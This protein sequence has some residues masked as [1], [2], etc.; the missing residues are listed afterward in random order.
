MGAQTRDFHTISKY[1]SM[2]S[3]IAILV[4]LI[5]IIVAL[6]DDAEKDVGTTFPKNTTIVGVQ[7]GT[8][9]FDFLQSLSSIVFA[10]QGQSIFME[11]M[12]EMKKP[13]EF[14]KSLNVAYLLM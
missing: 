2:P 3:T 11:L 7:E 9:V 13:K 12:T 5:I 8:S 10:Y 4:A 1:L 14:T 6:V